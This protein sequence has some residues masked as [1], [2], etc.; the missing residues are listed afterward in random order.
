MRWS[1]EKIGSEGEECGER[2]RERERERRRRSYNIVVETNN[3][4]HQNKI[5][6]KDR[7][8]PREYKEKKKKGKAESEKVENRNIRGC[9]DVR[10]WL[11]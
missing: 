4:G 8:C 2:E 6:R 7:Q 1:A 10:G 5:N 9:A 3:S 11:W